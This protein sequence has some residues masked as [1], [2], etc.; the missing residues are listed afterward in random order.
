MSGGQDLP[1]I[2]E[3]AGVKIHGG[4][5]GIINDHI[6]GATPVLITERNIVGIVRT[7]WL[8]YAASGRRKP[9]SGREKRN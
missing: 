6:H 7:G 1:W 3:N 5:G 2:N 9:K 4:M 8:H